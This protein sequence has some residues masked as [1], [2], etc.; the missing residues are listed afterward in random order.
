MDWLQ[1]ILIMCSILF[2]AYYL[3]RVIE[4]HSYEI[5]R[6]MKFI[7]KFGKGRDD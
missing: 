5:Q 2:S 7:A 6:E 3:G 4:I 1:T